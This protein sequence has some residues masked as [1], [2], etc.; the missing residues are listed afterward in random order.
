MDRAIMRRFK[1]ALQSVRSKAFAN[2]MLNTMQEENFVVKKSAMETVLEDC[3]TE[4][5]QLAAK[6]LLFW[7]GRG[8][9]PPELAADQADLEIAD[10]DAIVDWD[11][12]DEA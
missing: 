1:A 5:E 7:K 8:T 6:G 11:A 10:E 4:A 2:N 12:V 3:E 9:V